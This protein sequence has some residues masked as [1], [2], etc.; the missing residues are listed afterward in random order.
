M[1][2]TNLIE[3]SLKDLPK[4]SLAE[5]QKQQILFQLRKRNTRNKRSFK[6]LI[7]IV[8]LGMILV[9]LVL[10]EFQTKQP[11]IELTAKAGIA[12]IHTDTNQELIGI[13]GKV[14]ILNVFNH[15]V[16]EDERRGSKL[17]I[18]FWDDPDTF[19]WKD[20]R[21]E[22]MNRHNEKIILS[23]GTIEH[24]GLYNEDAHLLTQFSPFPEA[25]EWQLSFYVNDALFEEFTL[26]VLPPFPKTEHYTLRTSPK[27]IKV[28]E[29]SEVVIESI[30]EDKREIDVQLKDRLGR[31]VEQQTFH[32][33]G[34]FTDTATLKPLYTFDGTI[35]F[36]K[37]GIWTLVIDGEKTKRF[38]N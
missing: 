33:S 34:E 23:E 35:T 37:Q 30:G 2:E 22:A 11:Q 10:S 5:E 21:I 12:F 27:E 9:F 7:A 8:G 36:P 6:P 18:Y 13:E 14:G 1:K 15:F 19:I 3:E 29:K 20:Y 25:G 38:E 16:A 31:I 32:R 26:N 4:Y 24:G 28:G 17:M